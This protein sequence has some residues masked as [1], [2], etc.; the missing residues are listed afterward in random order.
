MQEIAKKEQAQK[1]QLKREKEAKR[2]AKEKRK[3]QIASLSFNPF[4]EEEEG[5]V[6]SSRQK[7]VL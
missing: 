6:S 5:L 7:L 1:D 4:D 3:Q 2:L